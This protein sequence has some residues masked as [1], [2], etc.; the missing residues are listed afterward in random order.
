MNKIKLFFVI[1]IIFIIIFSSSA[2]AVET[3]EFWTISLSP[4][5]DDY[6]IEQIKEFES[7]NPNVEILWE[8]LNFS[9]ITQKLRFSLAENNAPEVVNLSPQLM[10]SLLKDDLLFPISSLQK[11]YSQDYYPKLWENGHYKGKDYAFPW[12]LSPKVMVYNQE[13]FKIAGLN[14]NKTAKTKEDLFELAEEIKDKTGVFAF[15]PQLKIQHE[16]IEAG[17]SLF[18]KVDGKTRAAFNNQKAEKIISEYQK[19]VKKGV[20]PNDSLNSGFNIALERYQNNDLA[21]LF[22]PVQFVKD[23]ESESNYLRENSEI[24]AIPAAE[25]GIIHAALMNLVIPK[26]A[27]NKKIAADFAHF[28]TSAK[29]QKEFSTISSVYSSAILKTAKSESEN[30]DKKFLLSKKAD[31]IVNKDMNRYQ[32]LTLMHPKSAELLKI[33]EEQFARAFHGKITAKEALNIMEEKWNQIL[34]GSE[35]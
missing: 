29:A 7:K 20:I 10:A 11:D 1:S 15:M 22:T 27:D 16:F 13:I 21:I 8:D 4:S 33:M 31:Q 17:I 3:I 28:I 18:K 30:M 32:D 9:S 35:N 2:G 24:T 12:Y 23:I 26:A 19:L 6:F 5:F 25:E 34:A 14:P